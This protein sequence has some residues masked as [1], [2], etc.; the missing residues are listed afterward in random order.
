MKTGVKPPSIII[1]GPTP[2]PYHGVAIS[3]QLILQSPEFSD[4]NLVHLDTSDRRSISNIGSF[5]IGNITLGLWHALQ[6]SFLM[7]KYRPALV[8]LPLSQGTGGFLRDATFLLPAKWLR[9]PTII[10]LRGS[11]FQEFYQA[12]HPVLQW[13][14]RYS[15]RGITRAIV[16]GQ[17]LRYLF[18][19]LL[20]DEKI[21]VIPNGAE[22]FYSEVN[23]PEMA[24]KDDKVRGIY[25]GNLMS[26]KGVFVALKAA[27]LVARKHP[28]FEF[29]LAGQWFDQ[30]EKEQADALLLAHQDVADRIHF[31]GVVTGQT[32]YTLLQQCDFMVFPP[33][34]PEG[35]PRVVLESMVAGLPIISTDQGAISETV[36]DEVTGFI[37]PTND[38]DTVVC[39]MNLLIENA[40]KRLEMAEAAR[41]RYLKHYTI[42]QANQ[43]LAVLF[44]QVIAE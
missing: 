10:H 31:V 6:L 38:I 36:V 11:E 23:A 22:D 37:V 24:E 19:T 7:V 43:A 34:S 39:K 28:N 42:A 20:P 16:L 5:D 4:L 18:E 9:I 29:I 13:L 1:I 3:T 26:R 33:V 17:R 25:L 2:P 12:A 41:Q 8:Y 44:E 14:I 21:A 32:K 30:T 15:L 40:A 27:V 35:H